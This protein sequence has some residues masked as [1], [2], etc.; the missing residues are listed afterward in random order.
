LPKSDKICRVNTRDRPFYKFEYGVS[1]IFFIETLAGIVTGTGAFVFA[2]V[3]PSNQIRFFPFWFAITFAVAYFF[4]H[5]LTKVMF[6]VYPK[7]SIMCGIACGGIAGMEFTGL[8]LS[9]GY[10]AI[11]G[12]QFIITGI[13]LV[14]VSWLIL[15]LLNARYGKIGLYTDGIKIGNKV[16]FYPDIITSSYGTG[17]I[18]KKIPDKGKNKPVRIL[19]PIEYEY[20]EKNFGIFHV[21]LIFVTNDAVYVAQSLNKQSNLAQDTKNAWS[22]CVI[23]HE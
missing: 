22:R 5:V 4:G 16:F 10:F 8:L 15:F 17:P 9:F 7:L 23:G 12:I 2:I 19:T 6:F 18:E 14:L 20:I 3:L 21:Y 11:N 13:A 1:F